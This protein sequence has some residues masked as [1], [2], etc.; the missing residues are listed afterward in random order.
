[1]SRIF[2]SEMHKMCA[3]STNSVLKQKL[4]LSFEEFY[5]DNLLSEVQTHAPLLLS[6]MNACTQTGRPRSNRKA[7][8]GMC[9]AMI[10]RYRYSKMCL[11]QKIVALILYAGHSDKQVCV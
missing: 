8:I 1:M 6:F 11:V 10:L 2:W 5:W 9:I 7:T 3:D 4:P